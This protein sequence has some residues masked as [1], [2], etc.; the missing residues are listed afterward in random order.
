MCRKS[1]GCVLSAITWSLWLRPGAFA[2]VGDY[3]SQV[4]GNLRAIVFGLDYSLNQ[5]KPQSE[6]RRRNHRRRVRTWLLFG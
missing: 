6:R 5:K 4:Q 1:T 2:A 3:N